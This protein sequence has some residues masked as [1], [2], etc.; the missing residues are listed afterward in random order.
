MTAYLT[1]MP[2]KTWNFRY[3]PRCAAEVIHRW[4]ILFA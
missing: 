4:K 3:I 2:L 1:E